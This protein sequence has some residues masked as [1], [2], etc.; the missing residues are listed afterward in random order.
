MLETVCARHSCSFL[1]L[2]HCELDE[3]SR[4]NWLV[5]LTHLTNRF[6]HPLYHLL[7]IH[8]LGYT[9]KTFLELPTEYQPFGRG[10][11]PCLNPLSDH[12]RKPRIQEVQITIERHSRPVGTFACSCGFAYVRRGPDRTPEDRFR[13]S[14]YASFGPIWEAELKKLWRDPTVSLVQMA[15]QLGVD[16]STLAR[17]AA[18]M[19]LP[20]PHPGSTAAKPEISDDQTTFSSTRREHRAR[21]LSTIT[22]NPE[23][24]RMSLQRELPSVMKFKKI[25]QVL[26][27]LCIPPGDEFAWLRSNV[28]QIG[29]D[30]S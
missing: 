25:I 6:Q 7:L 4:D 8:F 2:L 14:R 21:L 13:I 18:K 12:Y 10:P 27:V 19:G 16:C 17:H 24:S 11:W 23:A 20:F 22:G 1:A 26:V 29:L 9:V 30:A 28:Q 5:R 15:Q 3:N